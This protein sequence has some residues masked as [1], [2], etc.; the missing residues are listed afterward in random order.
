M[1]Q[2]F[3]VLCEALTITPG[4]AVHCW[5]QLN[6]DRPS[7]C[8]WRVGNGEDGGRLPRN[9]AYPHGSHRAP[10]GVVPLLFINHAPFHKIAPFA[11]HG[12]QRQW[13]QR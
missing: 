6:S 9:I 11:V 12:R 10:C 8:C 5:Q 7:F 3:I 1:T 2:N 13:Q 4:C